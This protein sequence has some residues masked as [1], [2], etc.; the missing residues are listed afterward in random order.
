MSNAMDKSSRRKINRRHTNPR[1]EGSNV[2][3]TNDAEYD[4]RLNFSS[5][6]TF[7]VIFIRYHRVRLSR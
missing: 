3:E 2:I 4:R 7:V 5:E 6:G 1:S